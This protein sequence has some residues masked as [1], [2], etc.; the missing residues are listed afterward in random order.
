MVFANLNSIYAR[1]ENVYYIV[2][3]TTHQSRSVSVPQFSVK[4]PLYS[5]TCLMSDENN[6]NFIYE[7]KNDTQDLYILVSRIRK[8]DFIVFIGIWTLI[9]QIV[10]ISVPKQQYVECFMFFIKIFYRPLPLFNFA[11]CIPRNKTFLSLVYICIQ[12]LLYTT[13]ISFMFTIN[14]IYIKLSF[15]SNGLSP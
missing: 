14:D 10:P 13:D 8:N 3:P 4:Y 6:N 9:Y 12:F 15:I 7:E 2:S 5:Q 1:R 11:D